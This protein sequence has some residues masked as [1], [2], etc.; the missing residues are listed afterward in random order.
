M[1]WRE[2]DHVGESDVEKHCCGDNEDP[3]LC[4]SG[5]LSNGDADVQTNEC[6][7]SRYQLEDGDL[8]CRPTGRQHDSHVTCS[9][10]SAAAKA[11][12]AVDATNK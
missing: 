1:K 4:L 12:L 10:Q 2:T 11:A 8:Q 5:V 3:L 9:T 6:R 7:C